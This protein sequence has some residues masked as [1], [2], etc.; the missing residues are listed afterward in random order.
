[1]KDNL[2][3]NAGPLGRP[4]PGAAP[5]YSAGESPRNGHSS[6]QTNGH[7]PSK[8]FN[9][10]VALDLLAPRW[11]WL[12]LGTILCGGLF[13]L[14]GWY[15]VR[16][17][18]TA[19]AQLI[20]YDTP[21]MDEAFKGTPV[22]GDTFAALIQDPSLLKKV[23]QEVFPPISPDAL[24]KQLKV[25]PD[26]DSDLIKVQL[27][28]RDPRQAVD[29]LNIYLTN[30]VEYTRQL[31]A[32]QLSM[33]SSNFLQK[34][35]AEIDKDIKDL[36]A[37]FFAVP[38]GLGNTNRLAQTNWRINE[39]SQ[40]LQKALADL[41]DLKL[42]FTDIH[43]KVQAQEQ[44]VA[45]LRS[46]MAQA[47]TN[48]SQTSFTPQAAV[49]MTPPA[50]GQAISPELDIVHIKMRA[51]EDGRLE[52]LKR[53]REAELYAANEPGNVRV[54]AA[55]EPK[56]VKDNW[57]RL[58]IGLVTFIGGGLGLA[59]SLVLVFLVEFL[60]NRLKTPD[61]IT[62]VTKLP[63]LTTLGNLREM[64]PHDRAQWAFRAWTMLQGRL[65]PSA[66]HGLVCGITSSAP[67]EGRSTWISLL[68]EAASMTGFR[69]LT[70]ATRPSPEHVNSNGDSTPTEK[71]KPQAP[72]ANHTNNHSSAIT[73]SVLSSPA[74]VTEQ[75]IGPN[76]QPVVHIPLPGWVWNLERRC[77]WREALQ[78]WREIDNLVIL[79]ELPPA[80]LPEA[81]L[82]GS[83]L[84]N[85][86]W[87]TASGTAQAGE[88][89]EQLE[90]LRD[91]RC[92]L[93]GAVLN[94]EPGRPLKQR[95]PRWM[96]GFLAA[97]LLGLNQARAQGTNSPALAE[98]E[99]NQPAGSIAPDFTAQ[100]NAS[101]SV[102]N[103][104]QRAAWER[105][106]TLGPGDVLTLNLYGEP[107]LTRAQVAIGPDGRVS[108]LEAQDVMAAGLTVDEL[109]DKVDQALSEY[110][111][112][113]H[114]MI[115]PIAYRS[116]HYYM[117]GKVATKGVFVL[118]RPLTVLE[119][120][121]RAHGLENALVD[122]NVFDLADF[123]RSFLARRGKRF[124]LDFE[125]LFQQGDLSQNIAIEPGDYIYLAPG[126]I[127]QVY[128]LGE[129]RS[130]GTVDYIPTLT[131]V[132]AIAERGGYT[133]RAFKMRV[134]VMRGSLSN[135]EK[136]V[137]NT[138]AILDAQAPDF[139][140][141]PK[142]IIFV[143]SRPFI[144]VEEAADL[145]ATAFIQSV[146]ASWVG[147][148]VVQPFPLQ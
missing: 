14:L 7:S 74:K 132:G 45:Q 11:H 133:E 32:R 116:K 53:E 139:K 106:L 37:Q 122:R 93:V 120:L 28:A 27:A 59:A 60:D 43:P 131:V 89:R 121:G 99:A 125:R 26:P 138:H 146:I 10:W 111:R 31:A 39:L 124:A 67:G 97:G 80:C 85:M 30:A 73:P 130:P 8:P 21:G 76:S 87:L 20:R 40:R 123:K 65:S 1:M 127:N 140:L 15:V 47:A 91:A 19:N 72:E 36:E 94:R 69:V 107:A 81:V 68:A 70:I 50:P 96:G 109:R 148:D 101:F 4:N 13:Y 66:N 77:Q 84:P 44:A 110:R 103:P 92:N 22:S 100:T 64:E 51:L 98:P 118:D 41:D 5:E 63:V 9:M 136:F 6:F 35:V 95:F 104:A 75:L 128:V 147:V 48:Q 54:Y 90:T 61:D 114:C 126:D 144:K 17:K 62:R 56:T 38:P 33:I 18:F 117:L 105:H 83:N 2:N 46:E 42:H 102:F 82:L 55:A 134:I 29:L 143:N 141:Q 52:L 16:P 79:V 86:L 112:A 34:Q 119:A 24:S 3:A 145:A 25:D 71:P 57:R 108:Y 88:T 113:P 137:V 129:V 142:D 135:P 23:G 115:T 78:H 58:K 49:G 12:V